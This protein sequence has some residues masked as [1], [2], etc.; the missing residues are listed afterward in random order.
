MATVRM[1]EGDTFA[2]ILEWNA[3]NRGERPA[4]REKHL[5]IWQT[6]NWSMVRHEVRVIAHGLADIGLKRGDK[7]A[8]IGDNRPRLYWSIIAAQALGAIP[9]PMYQDAAANELQYVVDHA[10]VQYAV[11]EDQEQVD[12]LLEA[13]DVCETL[14]QIIYCDPRGMRNYKEDYIHSFASLEERGRAHQMA[15][16]G[17]YDEEVAKSRP[18]DTAIFL[19]TSGTTGNPK[20]VVLTFNNLVFMGRMSVELEQLKE[21]EDTLAYLPL[22]WVGDYIFSIAQSYVAGFCVNCPE[23]QTTVLQDLREIG[24]TYFFAPPRVFENLL[25]TVHV[26]MEDAGRLKRWMFARCMR[27]A[28]RVGIAK[29]NGESVGVINH[30]KYWIGSLFTYGPLKNT[31]GFSRLRRVYTAGEAIGPDIFDFYRALGLN[32]KQLYGQ[33]ESTVFVTMQP[34][35]EVY[36]DTVGVPCPG[37]DVK[38]DDATGEVMYRGP[39]VFKE[40]YRNPEATAEAKTDDGWVHTGDAGFF[41]TN[42]HLKIID[43]AKDVGKLNDNSMFAPKYIENKLKFFPFIREVIAFGDQQDFVTAMISIDPDA[44]GNWAERNNISYASYRE[45]ASKE[46]VYEIIRENLEQVNRELATDPAIASSQIKRFVLLHKELDADDGELTRTRKVRRRFVAERYEPVIDAF[47]SGAI[48]IHVE[49]ET[50]FED[51]R[52]GVAAGDLL[53]MDVAV[54]DAVPAQ[55]AA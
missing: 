45:L 31:L 51:G 49:I 5:G 40:Y 33:T 25:T 19:Y 26:R 1:A 39:G 15:N 10:E 32:M 47:Y 37:V 46:K 9:V 34:D 28:K 14:E 42:K 29:V 22:A 36:P 38:I 27:L 12:K 48:D 43:R 13:L 17:F 50:I 44:V 54:I 55:A 3:A 23:S 30:I 16:P 7:I 11:A 21:D 4:I 20:G 8:I 18:E 41:D 6:W 35:D 24:P 52:K 53:I 2:K